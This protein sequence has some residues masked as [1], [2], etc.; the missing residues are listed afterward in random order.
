[1]VSWFS[2][3]FQTALSGPSYNINGN[4]TI[5]LPGT[6]NFNGTTVSYKRRGT[7]ETYWVQGPLTSPMHF[8]VRYG[9]RELKNSKI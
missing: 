7:Q 4:F 3:F 5:K 2:L 9:F 8:K 6:Y 1:M